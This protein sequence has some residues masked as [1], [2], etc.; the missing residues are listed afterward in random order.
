[1][2]A[3]I[4]A[5]LVQLLQLTLRNV[6]IVMVL[7]YHLMVSI[8]VVVAVKHVQPIYIGNYWSNNA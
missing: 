2:I 8:I 5:E 3:W 7:T 4:K 1:M 6:S